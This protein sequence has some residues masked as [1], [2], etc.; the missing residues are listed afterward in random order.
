MK[1]LNHHQRY[2][3][4][5]FAEDYLA[6][7]MSRRDLLRRSLLATGSITL[8]A[9]TLFALGCGSSDGESEATATS[10]PP[11]NTP[12]ASPP[13]STQGGSVAENDPA[14]Q[15]SSVTFRGTGGDVFGYLARP[16]AGNGP[17]PGVVIIHENRGLLPH[18][19]DLSRRYAKAGFVALA[20]DLA[21]RAGGTATGAAT[22]GQANPTE[23][24][25]DLQ[26][27][28]DYLKSQPYIN[29][30]AL[31]VTGFCFGG[32][33]AFDLTAASDDIKAAVPYYGTANRALENGLTESGA[34]IFVVY[35]G[36][37]TRITSERERVEA[38]LQSTGRP[39]QIRV[40][41]GAGHAFFNDTG[42]SYNEQ[43]A[44]EA[45]QATIAWF[46]EHLRA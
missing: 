22:L 19:E 21:S 32:G 35:G 34:A 44:N 4:E 39:Y 17:F 6:R 3:I 2:L 28:L 16:A 15:A 30:N 5:E 26:S 37:D 8:T 24:V 7:H 41:D 1:A 40:Y 9:S 27:G 33:Y 42:G 23:L 38:A 29:D 43:A 12:P 13:A 31:G 25:Q 46:R 45:W 11:E 10:A 14:V 20:V 36:N 18:F